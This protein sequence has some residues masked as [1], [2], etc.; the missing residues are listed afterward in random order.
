MEPV[1]RKDSPVP[2][3]NPGLVVGTERAAVVVATLASFVTPFMGSSVNVALPAIGRE[4]EMDALGLSWVATA[5]LLTAAV[6]LV[7]FGKLADIRGRKAVFRDGILLYT[8]ASLACGLVPS[9]GWL[10]AARAVQGLGAAGMF[11]TNVAILTSVIPPGRRGTALGI[12]VASVYLGLSLGPF[13][14]G[15]LTDHFGW[16]SI[17]LLNGPLGLGVV[18]LVITKLKG[19]WA[20]DRNQRFDLAGSMLYG[21]SLA[22]L[23]YGFGKLPGAAGAALSGAGAAGLVSFVAWERRVK[24]P[25]LDVRLFTGNRL[26][27]MSNLA[28]LINYSATFAVGFL[29]SLYLQYV[30]GMSAQAAGTLLVFQPALQAAVSPFAGR[31]SDKVES[32]IVASGGMGLI[33]VGLSLLSFISAATPPWFVAG[34]LMFLGIGFGLF[35]SPNTNAVMGAVEPRF[36]AIASATLA[37]M[38]LLGQM[39]SMGLAML[40]FAL[41]LG[42]ARVSAETQGDFVD[43]A[44]VAFGMFAALSVVGALA[45]L[46]R[47]KTR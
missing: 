7:P 39:V 6:F 30:R 28:A 40:V 41:L 22:L 14:G 5:Y 43:A 24:N 33:V 20:G 46:V 35:S 44:R 10:I 9:S 3:T 25:V 27:A 31:L 21:G 23:M 34:C 13:L 42:D 12:N 38:R 8:L 17:F 16:R 4:L 1:L 15:I 29:L 11:G 19:E 36:Y 37:T 18:S 26:F 32:R 47:G 2:T 45:S